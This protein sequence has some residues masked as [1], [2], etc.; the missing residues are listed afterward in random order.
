MKITSRDNSLLRHARAVRD[1]KIPE[2]IFI[3]GLRLG[4]EALRS[5]L[6]IEAVIYSEQIVKKDR[7]ASLIRELEKAAAKSATVSEKLLTSISYTKT[8]QGIVVLAARP[9][10]SE[11]DF[12]RRQTKEPLLVILHRINNPVN[13]GA[14]MRTGEAAGATGVLTT[15]GTTDPFSAKSLRGAMGAAFR[16]PVW[17]D[18]DYDKAIDWCR[19]RSIQ[20]ICADIGATKSHTDL[21]WTGPTALIVGSESR[22][23]SASEIALADHAVKIPMKGSTESLNAAVAAG[24]LLYEAARQRGM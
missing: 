14:I 3:E 20:T 16:V 4:E 24:I 6:V 1:G 19:K 23:L 5:N 17:T 7:A 2:S 22:G 12:T 13:L 15:V 21:N 9:V 10:S 18:V 11:K 8:P